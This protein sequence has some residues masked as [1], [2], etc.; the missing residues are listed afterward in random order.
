MT[1]AHKTG[2]QGMKATAA[3]GHAGQA[4][5]RTKVK[6]ARIAT[7]IANGIATG[8][9]A[10]RTTGTRRTG[11]P[12]P[13]AAGSRRMPSLGFDKA[14]T[15]SIRTDALGETS[16][17]GRN[18]SAGGMT[19]EVRDPLPLGTRVQVYFAMPD[20][21]ARIVASGQVKNHYC[22]NFGDGRGGTRAMN[23]VGVRFTSFESE[24]DLLLGLGIARLRTVLH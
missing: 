10:K 5:S 4:E 15:V 14:F 18:I 1:T 7:K 21:A 3:A 16:A 11:T 20:S 8:S 17:V 23:G 24:S 9:R 22:L 6:A 13:V 12:R 2:R 19:L